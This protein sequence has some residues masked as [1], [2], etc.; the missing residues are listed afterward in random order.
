MAIVKKVYAWE[1]YQSQ[2]F[3]DSGRLGKNHEQALNKNPVASQMFSELYSCLYADTPNID[4][5]DVDPDFQWA[6]DIFESLEKTQ[7]FIDLK[8]TCKFKPYLAGNAASQYYSQFAQAIENL[9]EQFKDSGEKKQKIKDL[10]EQLEKMQ[11]KGQGDGE[12]DGDTENEDGEGSGKSGGEDEEE[13]IKGE[14]KKLKDSLEQAEQSKE[15][16]IQQMQQKASKEKQ[17][18]KAKEKLLES[19][20]WGSDASNLISALD[21]QD[22]LKVLEKIQKNPTLNQVFNFAGG[23]QQA[24]NGMPKMGAVPHLEEITAVGQGDDL[25]ALFPEEYAKLAIPSLKSLFGLGL[26]AKTLS[27]YTS[28]GKLPRKCGPMVLCVDVSGSMEGSRAHFASGVVLVALKLARK[29]QREAAVIFFDGVVQKTFYFQSKSSDLEKMM[30]VC[31]FHTGGGTDWEAPLRAA[32]GLISGTKYT[33]KELAK[34]LAVS[35]E[36]AN[37][38]S[39]NRKSLKNSSIIFITDGYCYLHD[40]FI[41]EYKE[42]SKKNKVETISVGIGC[43]CGEVEKLQEFSNSVINIENIDLNDVSVKKVS[44][45]NKVFNA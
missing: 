17:D 9:S 3:F 44:Q 15:E 32:Q 36:E 38:I 33:D 7:D 40:E 10:Q 28:Q 23:I 19:I 29:Q 24:L 42:T 8:K 30:K 31:T 16:L 2:R 21:D 1:R 4:P 27:Q 35:V 25:E 11:G 5:E 20:T 43:G 6:S 34:L 14:I 22:I 26:A 39:K 37:F 18:A 45:L 12:G 41:K 13:K